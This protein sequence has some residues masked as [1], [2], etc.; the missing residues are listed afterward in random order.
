[1]SAVEIYERDQQGF[2]GKQ[3]TN[4]QVGAELLKHKYVKIG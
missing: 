2:N 3:E 4:P 1:M